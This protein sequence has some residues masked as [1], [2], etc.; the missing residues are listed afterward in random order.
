MQ[1]NAINPEILEEIKKIRNEI[2]DLKKLKDETGLGEDIVTKAK[3][4]TKAK[5]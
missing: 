4:A 5:I 1:T 3:P 2:N